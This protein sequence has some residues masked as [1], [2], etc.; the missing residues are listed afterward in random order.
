[1]QLVFSSGERPTACDPRK[2]HRPDLNHIS[3][4]HSRLSGSGGKY[5]QHKKWTLC[6]VNLSADLTPRR[7]QFLWRMPGYHAAVPLVGQLS[8]ASQSKVVDVC[9]ILTSSKTHRDNIIRIS[10]L[11]PHGDGGSRFASRRCT[12]AR[13]FSTTVA[14]HVAVGSRDP[15]VFVPCEHETKPL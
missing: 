8:L 10:P 7:G 3:T 13:R 14:C 15:G 5:L 2:Q 11:G 12:L 9:I 6:S 4:Q 1:M